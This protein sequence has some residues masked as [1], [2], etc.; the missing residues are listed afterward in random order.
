MKPTVHDASHH[1]GDVVENTPMD[2]A[3]S[4]A[5]DW[6][7]YRD[8]PVG[9]DNGSLLR[10]RATAGNFT[11]LPFHNSHLRLESGCKAG[12]TGRLHLGCVWRRGQ[13]HV[14]SEMMVCRNATVLVRN[15]FK[16]YTG[17]TVSVQENAQLTLGSGF[18]NYGLQLHCLQQI[19]IGEGVAISENVRIRD[20][21]NHLTG[22]GPKAQPVRI[23]D[24]ARIGMAA[25]ILKGVTVGDGAFVA[26][27]SVVVHD[28]PPKTL[29]AGVP[30]VVKKT[31]VTWA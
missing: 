25:T 5:H 6:R 27:G 29:V 20:S 26:T 17:R 13:R 24:H 10:A 11:I 7:T 15:T 28:V 23:G 30:A 12:G 4:L 31:G 1:V 2:A 3:R 16:V 9:L 18:C 14:A 22:D 21:A 8:Y 19:E